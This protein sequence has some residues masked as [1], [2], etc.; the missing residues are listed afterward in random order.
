MTIEYY[1]LVIEL[2]VSVHVY[3]VTGTFLY[4][5]ALGNAIC[6]MHAVFLS[7]DCNARTKI[8][9]TVMHKRNKN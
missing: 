4:Y 5:F 1:L 6:W 3:S 2:S 7:F 9:E 8:F